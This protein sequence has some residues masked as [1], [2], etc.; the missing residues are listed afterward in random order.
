M[1]F[2]TQTK[3]QIRQE[4]VTEKYEPLSVVMNVMFAKDVYQ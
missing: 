4:I 3:G 1:Y 2:L